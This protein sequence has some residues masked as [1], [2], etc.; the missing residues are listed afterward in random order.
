MT[1]KALTID[2][3]VLNKYPNMVEFPTIE[4]WRKTYL[5]CGVK[6]KTYKSSIEALLRRFLQNDYREIIPV[7]DLYN[8]V[9]A[10]FIISLG[11]YDLQKL[12]GAMTLRF[13]KPE[14]RF[15]PLN[16]K[17]DIS[18]NEE[19]IVYAD[20]NTEAPVI[21]WMWNHKD[22][23]RAMLNNDVTTGLFVFDCILPEDRIRLIKAQE[24]FART[25][26]SFGATVIRSGVL[27]SKNATV[28][29]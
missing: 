18:V 20:E 11:G 24:R 16:G 7:V 9:S 19:H 10:G 5:N 27:D 2:Q 17:E 23:R 14:D 1:Q 4:A 3:E 13:G 25:L 21:C 12:E 29:L 28:N 22:C 8:Y 6:P 26:T 15:I